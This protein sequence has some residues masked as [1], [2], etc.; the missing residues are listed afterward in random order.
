[1]KKIYTLVFFSFSFLLCSSQVGQ[2]T[3]IHGSSTT[4]SPGSTGTRGAASP[5]NE[6]PAVYEGVEWTDLTG[7][8][9]LFGG[10]DGSYSQHGDLWMFDPVINEWTWVSG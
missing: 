4:G 9:W 3:W 8:L 7:K 5:T 6:P 1:M 10:L 2:W